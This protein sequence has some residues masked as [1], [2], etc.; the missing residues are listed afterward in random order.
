MLYAFMKIL[1]HEY[2]IWIGYRMVMLWFL[3]GFNVEFL[4]SSY[5]KMTMKWSFSCNFFVKLSL[6]NTIYL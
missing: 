2:V 4:Q 6:Y 3:I 1:Q 5:R